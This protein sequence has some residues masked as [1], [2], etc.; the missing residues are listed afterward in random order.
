VSI[1]RLPVACVALAFGCAFGAEPAADAGMGP[2]PF[3]GERAFAQL[4]KLVALGPRVA[5][6]EASAAARALVRSE[7]EAL[8][9]EVHEE[10]F[11]RPG[12]PGGPGEPGKP[13]EPALELANLWAEIPGKETGIFVVATPLDTAP[14]AGPG[15]N[16]GGSGAALL[17]EL[18][19]TLRE[20]PLAYPV[21]L[22]FLDAELLDP[23]APFLGSQ[24]AHRALRESGALERLRLLLYLHQVADGEL[25]IRRDRLSDRQLRD[26]FFA[27]AQ[28]RG[29]AGAFP[30]AAPFDEVRL[31]HVVFARQRFPGVVA[32]AD[33]R[34]GGSEIPGT[35]WRTEDGLAHC[36]AES[37]AA[38]GTLVRAGLAA[39]AE[40]QRTVDRM[41]LPALR[42]EESHP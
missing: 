22:L 31:G 27:V 20:Q 17:L 12:G 9:L 33:L 24:H 36:S 19:R 10:A 42:T 23:K 38:V 18:A 37:L 5:G 7:L 34:Y 39:T 41:M 28:K 1:V 2:D 32:L 15:A 25:E 26:L 13:G 35:H 14:G 3:S 8:G 16:E 6:T 4:E 29:L 21:R 40:R 11:S 30:S